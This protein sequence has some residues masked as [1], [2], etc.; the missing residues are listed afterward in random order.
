MPYQM[1]AVLGTKHN[2]TIILVFPPGEDAYNLFFLSPFLLKSVVE[3]ILS[4]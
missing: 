1:S 2:V 4:I 3:Y